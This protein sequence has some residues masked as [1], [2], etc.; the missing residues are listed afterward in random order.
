MSKSLIPFGNP[1]KLRPK[2]IF[3][4]GK[5]GFKSIT[6]FLTYFS[7]GLVVFVALLFAWFAK[8]LPTPGK[9]AKRAPAQSTKIFDRTGN[10]LYETGIQKRTSVESDKIANNLKQAT[11]SIE[12]K[13]FFK[14]HGFDFRGILRAAYNDIFKKGS[15]QGGSTITQ[16]FVKTAL[17]DSKRT[18]TRKIKELIISIEI[19]QM[20]SKDQILAMYL[21]EIPYG[22]NVAGT[23]AAAQMYYNIPASNLSVAQAA[24]LAAIPRSPTYYS[25][26]GTHTKELIVR[27]DYILG[28]MKDQGYINEQQLND[29]KNIDTTTVNLDY[30][31]NP[32]GVRPRKDSIKAPHFAL[33]VLDQ[34]VEKYGDEKINKEGLKVITTLDSA[35]QTIAEKVV[36]EG[37]AKNLTRY[38]ANNA[39]LVS[40]DPKTGQVLSM[41]GSKDFF[42][43][44]IDGNFNVATAKRQPGSSFKPIV[45]STAFKKPENSPSRILFDLTTDFGGNYIPHNY[46]NRTNG[47]VTMRF[48]LSNSLNIP[49]VKTLALA[50]I[51]ES[52]Q[53][54]ADLGIT[55]LDKPADHYGLSL[56]LGTGEVKLLEMTGAFSVFANKGVKE[57]IKTILKV[58]DNR[59][60][61]LY[62]YD[63]NKEKGKVAIDPQ[64][65][66]EISNILSDNKTRSAIFGS[67]SALAFPDRVVA[68][69]TGTTS[70]FKDGWTLGYTP[71]LAAGVWVGN[72]DSKPMV[73]G[74]AVM[75][76]GPIFHQFMIEA[77]KDVP[78][79]E[80]ER[81]AGIVD[82]TVDKF[83]NKLPSELST[84]QTT[85]IFASWQVPKVQD[86]IHLKLRV[87]KVNG[88]L[89]ADDIL[90]GLIEYRTYINIHSEFPNKPNWEGPVRAWAAAAGLDNLPPTTN[91]DA[92]TI[93]PSISITSP[94]HNS[95]VTGILNLTA[96]VGNAAADSTVEYFID[97]ISVGSTAS[98]Y[99]LTYNSAAL[100]EG[101]HHLSA[102]LHSSGSTV[103][104][105]ID[106]NVQKVTTVFSNVV[107]TNIAPGQT[108]ITWQTD[109]AT[110]SRVDFGLVSGSYTGTENNATLTQNHSVI[111]TVNPVTKYYYK[112]FGVDGSGTL[113]SSNEFSFTSS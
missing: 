53:T 31:K 109:I 34:L 6:K 40:I 66:Y 29:A 7:L 52:L 33:H 73:A 85:D 69:K 106:F 13:D 15:T 23:E 58:E 44:K 36:S 103:K 4:R 30:E 63:E 65:A 77:L 56:V 94:T 76:A 2:K 100:S 19:E 84:E 89:A 54:A 61:V 41:V 25:P 46:N 60:K 113:S 62:E 45:Y 64:I 93:T 26:Y 1:L 9:I 3:K 83:S 101:S 72:N 47:P 88:L 97:N 12:D 79:Q 95:T 110:N 38:K 87:C 112:L 28:K 90:E 98:P 91:C 71:T 67:N 11:V 32:V 27:R 24:T 107:A 70:E 99:A 14:H 92:T 5:F 8:D 96:S 75:A 42:D 49:A 78:N 22:S 102:L 104:S 68:A 18:F 35:K 48:A 17:L 43:T 80:F 21:N 59:G 57:E 16:Q 105:E 81:P 74:E 39:A 82:V 111:L 108:K 55:T 51:K 86:D 50:G 37:A 10:L 20:Y